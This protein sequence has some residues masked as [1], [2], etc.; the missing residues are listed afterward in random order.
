MKYLHKKFQTGSNSTAY[1]DNWE[2]MFG[3]TADT[4]EAACDLCRIPVLSG[5]EEADSIVARLLSNRQDNETAPCVSTDTAGA[6][7]AREP[8][9]HWCP[10]WD[11]AL[12]HLGDPEFECCVCF[13]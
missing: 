9:C 8:Y 3:N 1:K 5:D 12:V 2:R 10:D 7:P 4:T 6:G 11:Y 13:K